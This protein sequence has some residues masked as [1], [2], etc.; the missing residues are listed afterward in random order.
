MVGQWKNVWFSYCSMVSPRE[1]V[2]DA[3]HALSLWGGNN[4]EPVPLF[5]NA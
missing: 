4:T 2:T 3:L 5:F 1:L